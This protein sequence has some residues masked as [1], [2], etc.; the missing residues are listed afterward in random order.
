MR[1]LCLITFAA[2]PLQ[3]FVVTSSPFGLVRVHQAVLLLFAAAYLTHTPL[4]ALVPVVYGSRFFLLSNAMMLSIWFAVDLYHGIPPLD[5]VQE[6]PYLAVFLAIAS[7]FYVATTAETCTALE[8]MRWSVV[9]AA[10]TLVGAL[11]F[12]MLHN[13]VNPAQIFVQ[14]IGS[15]NPELLSNKLFKSAFGGFGYNDATVQANIRHEVFGGLLLALCVS[16]WAVN[17]QPFSRPAQYWVFRLFVFTSALLIAFSLS[18]S[19]IIAAAVWP[20]VATARALTRFQ[21]S[22]RQIVIAYLVISTVVVALMSGFALV[23]WRRFTTDT[24]SYRGRENL[25]SQAWN[26][27]SHHFF[28]GGVN[29]VGASSHNFIIDAWLRGGIFVAIPA[30]AV[31]I[32]VLHTVVSLMRHLPRDPA[33]TVPL[34]AALALPIVRLGTSGGGL[35]N[36]VEWVALG[37]VA[38]VLAARREEGKRI[39]SQETAPAPALAGRKSLSPLVERT[40]YRTWRGSSILS[41]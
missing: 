25:Y 18:R 35:L 1:R 24:S 26:E 19:I 29:T 15:G 38:G 17:R 32:L 4:R 14:S 6:M 21:V 34:I 28:T 20:V 23:L 9:A 5:P 10:V 7:Y 11:S 8:L 31:V 36:P 27:I 13:G 39:R 30:A 41:G 12:S 16:V 40:L 3:W 22:A 2:L 33:W 37:F